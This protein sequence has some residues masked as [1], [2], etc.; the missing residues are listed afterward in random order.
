MQKEPST[1]LEG[2]DIVS[3]TLPDAS[4]SYLVEAHENVTTNSTFSSE[5]WHVR[6]C[7]PVRYFKKTKIYNLQYV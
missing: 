3:K 1:L 4:C 6:E 5:I 2:I 7:K